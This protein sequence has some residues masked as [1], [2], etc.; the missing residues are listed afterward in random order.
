MEVE[1][2]EG[3]PFHDFLYQVQKTKQG[4]FRWLWITLFNWG[5][6]DFT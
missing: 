2:G 5:L 3:F 6:I 4:L 1:S